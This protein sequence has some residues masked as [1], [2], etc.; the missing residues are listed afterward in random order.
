M[1]VLQG[2]HE[3]KLLGHSQVVWVCCCILEFQSS[4]GTGS[5]NSE[6]EASLGQTQ[7]QDTYTEKP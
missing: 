1:P 6:F 7:F 4:G 5:G 2:F 3:K